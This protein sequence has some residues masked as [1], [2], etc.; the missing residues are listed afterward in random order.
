[1]R[2]INQ[3]QS[4]IAKLRAE[5]ADVKEVELSK[6][7]AIHILKNL[8]W[9]RERGHWVKPKPVG[10][11]VGSKVRDYSDGV[12]VQFKHGYKR[13]DIVKRKGYFGRWLVRDVVSETRLK[14]SEIKSPFGNGGGWP[15][16]VNFKYCIDVTEV[17]KAFQ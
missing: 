13:G 12:G 6:N 16:V 2:T 3:I 4:E 15:A 10:A 1:M 11:G 9:T 14:V 8:G 17:T 5:M 7:D